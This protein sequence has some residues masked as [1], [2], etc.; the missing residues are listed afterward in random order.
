VIRI[1][2]LSVSLRD[3]LMHYGSKVSRRS[4]RKRPLEPGPAN[5]DDFLGE[6]L[7]VCFQGDPGLATT[8][9]MILDLRLQVRHPHLCRAETR[10]DSLMTALRMLVHAAIEVEDANCRQILKCIE[11]LADHTDFAS[12]AQVRL[13]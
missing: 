8:L 2:L 12:R 10:S 9:A 1:P 11:M 13:H 7:A 4:S 3:F 6:A 5:L